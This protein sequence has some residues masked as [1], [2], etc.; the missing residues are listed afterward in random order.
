MVAN[1]LSDADALIESLEQL[2]TKK[3]HLKQ[4]AMQE[5][6]TGKTRLA[7]FASLRPATKRTEAGTIPADWEVKP[8]REIA[9][10]KTGPFG[11]LLKAVEYSTGAGVP[12]IS[13]REIR[14]GTIRV[15]EDTPLVPDAVV[16]RLPQFVLRAGDIVFARKGSVER[17]ALIRSQEAGWFLGS[18]GLC[19][20]P[21]GQCRPE[22]VALQ[23]QSHRVREWLLQHAT[24]TTMASLNQEILN[25][26]AV[27]IPPSLAEQTAIAAVL[28]DMD[29]EIAAL[30]SKLA[31]ARAIKQGMM[32]NL[33]TGRIRLL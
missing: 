2:L 9:V 21:F 10:T 1:A 11:T 17:S 29:A 12:L 28:S 19:I 16:R 31:K 18:D 30:E 13:V 24:G 27:I 23:L 22:Y 15:T 20:R 32:D 3:R 33:L 14:E 5:L 26:V 6:L 7:P 8:L 25:K 4:G